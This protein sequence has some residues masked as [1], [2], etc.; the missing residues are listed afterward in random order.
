VTAVVIDASSGA[1]IVT[2]T[3]R[4]RALL[5]LLPTDA[6]GWVPQHFYAEV[7]GVLRHQ[8][9]F[10]KI[11]TEQQAAAALRR[12]QTWH[13]H[14][15]AVP[16]LLDGAWAFRHNLRAADALYVVLALELGAALLSDD[17]KLLS[18]PTFPASIAVLRLPFT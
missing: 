10:A 11:L 7:L 4:G 3:A 6:E 17:H 16:P 14:Q 5:R 8:T 18:S 12:L 2:D 1:E 13:V 15:A 9:V